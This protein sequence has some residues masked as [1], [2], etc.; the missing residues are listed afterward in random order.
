M[1]WC[2]RSKS[3][4]PT[5]ERQAQEQRDAVLHWEAQWRQWRGEGEL[6]WT[7]RR[8]CRIGRQKLPERLLL[9]SSEQLVAWLGQE[10]RWRR[11]CV[12]RRWLLEKWPQLASGIARYVDVLS[13]ASEQDFQRL[14][15]VLEWLIGNPDTGLYIRQL[16]VKGIHTK[17]VETRKT[18]LMSL[19]LAIRG[20]EEGDFFQVTGLRREPALLRFLLLDPGLRRKVGGLGDIAAPLDE[21]ARLELPVERVIIVENLKTGLAFEDLP[22]TLLVMGLG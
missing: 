10:E 9:Y 6:I 15:M 18:L 14:V 11:G 17:W 1:R 3:V 13:D 8:W 5:T 20:G 22:G 21:V 12:R 16:P 7:Q 19:L 4:S 2:G